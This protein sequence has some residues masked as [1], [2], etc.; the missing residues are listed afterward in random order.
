MPATSK[1]RWNKGTVEWADP[2]LPNTMNISVVFSWDA[3]QAYSRAV[4]HRQM[5]WNVRV[6]GP[7]IFVLKKDFDGIATIGGDIPD[8][9]MRHNPSATF[10]SR[11]CPVGCYF[12][13]VPA[14]EGRTFTL[15]DDFT[16]RPILCDNNLSALPEEFQN[17]VISRYKSTGVPLLDA[18]SGFEPQT[19][20]DA[21]LARW[22]PINRGPWR[23][24]YDET[25]EGDD[26]RRVCKMLTDY[27]RKRK[28]VY[29]LIGNEPFDACMA[30]IRQVLD[31][32]AEPH[33]QPIMKLNAR[34]RK[35]WIRYDWTPARLQQV[36]RWAN[37]WVW[38]KCAFKDYQ[39]LR[40]NRPAGTNQP[41]RKTSR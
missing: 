25:S 35:H 16:P 33:V 40:K 5:G 14:M 34:E 10:A 1:G 36:A 18:N 38:R 23:F 27:P 11:G 30:R 19:F 17:H 4:W 15:I 7:G 2:V 37:R 31:W 13:V 41:A 32:G 22:K 3:A 26:V 21:V 28:R 12:C 9:V 6:G 29:V 24:A 8:T 39:P 20:D